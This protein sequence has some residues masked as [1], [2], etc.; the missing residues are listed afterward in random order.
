MEAAPSTGKGLAVEKMG[1][2]RVIATEELGEMVAEMVGAAL[3]VGSW[4][5]TGYVLP[6]VGATADGEDD[7]GGGTGAGVPGAIPSIVRLGCGVA[8]NV[9]VRRGC[10]Q[11]TISPRLL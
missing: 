3:L 7:V 9:A 10:V 8:S 2:A 1:A 11:S 5:E 6:D 4:I